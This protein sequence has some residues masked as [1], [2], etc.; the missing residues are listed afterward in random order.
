MS[1]EVIFAFL[2]ENSIH[3]EKVDAGH[4]L[5]KTI[6]SKYRNYSSFSKPPKYEILHVRGFYCFDGKFSDYKRTFFQDKN[7]QEWSLERILNQFSELSDI[8]LSHV[9][10][11]I[12]GQK[13]FD[14]HVCMNKQNRDIKCECR[15][16]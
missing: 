4:N 5:L 13:I 12:D 7:L 1:T 15:K 3:K 6:C 11:S 9:S 14:G 10:F 2:K 8:E 16:L